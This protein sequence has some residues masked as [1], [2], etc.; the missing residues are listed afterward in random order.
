[1]GKTIACGKDCRGNLG[2]A[3]KSRLFSSKKGR[4]AD[5][6]TASSFFESPL[7]QTLTVCFSDKRAACSSLKRQVSRA[8]INSSF[9]GMT[10]KDT[11][12]SGV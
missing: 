7:F 4:C 1:M 2:I 5:R 8:I 9:A 10:S 3:G 6:F 11:F 12:E